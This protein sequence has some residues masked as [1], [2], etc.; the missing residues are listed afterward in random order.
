MARSLGMAFGT[1]VSSTLMAGFLLAYGGRMSGGP[2]APWVP[3]MRYT[4][5]ILAGL[6]FIAALLSLLKTEDPA[7]ENREK[8]EVPMEF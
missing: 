7:Q 2:R 3:T 5:L 6:A 4:L 1:A 8:I